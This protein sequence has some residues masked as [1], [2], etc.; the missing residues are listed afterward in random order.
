MKENVQQKLI[1]I[2]I[3]RTSDDDDPLSSLVYTNV[4]TQQNSNMQLC[5]FREDNDSAD[6]VDDSET[7]GPWLEY[8][9]KQT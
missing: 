5:T 6:E 1:N 9:W 3:R 4:Q 8:V 7:L 2:F